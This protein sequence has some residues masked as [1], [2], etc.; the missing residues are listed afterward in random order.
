MEKMIWKWMLTPDCV[1]E[2]PAGA[3]VLTV[4]TQHG[5][6]QIWAL[7]DPTRQKVRRR[8]RTYGTGHVVPD[9]PGEYV[10]TFQ[11][12]GGALVFHVFEGGEE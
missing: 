9:Y 5:E 8:F 4:Q 10:G 2:M 3:L 11:L 1:I 6:P 7:V 12:S